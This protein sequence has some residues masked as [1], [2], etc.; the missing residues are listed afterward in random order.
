MINKE[1]VR[2]R[3]GRLDEYLIILEKL[4]KYTWEDFIND[5]E[6]Y[7]SADRF[8]HLAIEAVNDIGSH[9]IADE[10]LGIVDAYRDIPVILYE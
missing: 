6:H 4:K 1:I 5:P 7:G 3:L 9:I 8:L 10:A 2:K